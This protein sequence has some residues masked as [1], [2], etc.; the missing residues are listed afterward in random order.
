MSWLLLNHGYWECFKNKLAKDV[1][2]RKKKEKFYWGTFYTAYLYFLTY[3][4]VLL[5]IVTWQC[6][7][8]FC[9]CL[10]FSNV[11]L[12][13]TRM[14]CFIT[15]IY[16]FEVKWSE[17]HQSCPTLCNPMDSPWNSPGQNTGV[18]S[19]SLL[20]RIFPTQGSIPCLPYY[21]HVFGIFTVL[22][23]I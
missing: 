3:K 14:P 10:M 12:R 5:C 20:Q 22:L 23:K 8:T 1:I 4:N 17:S 21:R 18:G 19:F 6:L 13:W 9:F 15:V 2:E 16:K 7:L 11:V